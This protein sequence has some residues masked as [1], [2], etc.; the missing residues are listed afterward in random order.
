MDDLTL[1]ITYFAE[2]GPQ[3]TEATLKAA[4]RRASELSI[5]RF[6]IAT[7]TGKTARKLIEAAPEGSKV[8]VVS[9]A[10]G[11]ALP[12]ER[13]HDY[14]PRF[15]DHKEELVRRG[16]RGIPASLSNTAVSVLEEQ[17]AVVSRIDW[18][19]FQLFTRS[20]LGSIDKLGVGVRV[21]FTVAVW[22]RIAEAIPPE[23]EVIAIAGT[24]FG[25]GGA[26]T[27]I[28]VQVTDAWKDFRILEPI[29]RPRVSPPSEMPG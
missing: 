14:L 16:L 12:V 18:K 21:A 19:K 6:V 17:G 27:A 11:L 2:P 24:G 1:S 13:L 8:V 5:T 15:K 9:N 3:N 10:A 22:A 26:D 28:V 23:G 20:G 4:L 29:V 25:G 7:D